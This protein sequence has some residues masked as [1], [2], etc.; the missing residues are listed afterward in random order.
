MKK[1]NLKGL[2]LNK[3]TISKLQLK[4]TYGGVMIGATETM[5]TCPDPETYNAA[6]SNYMCDSRLGGCK[7]Y[8][9]PKQ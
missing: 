2:S 9:C 5:A 8:Y 1:K 7:T 4:N 6:C 3:K